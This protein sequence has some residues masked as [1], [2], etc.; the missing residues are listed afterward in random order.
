MAWLPFYVRFREGRTYWASIRAIAEA[1][2][3]AEERNEDI[4]A[5]FGKILSNLPRQILLKDDGEDNGEYHL[6]RIRYI[7]RGNHGTVAGTNTTEE[8]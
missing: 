2:L 1:K 7:P 4:V 3:H 6:A 5:S 8:T